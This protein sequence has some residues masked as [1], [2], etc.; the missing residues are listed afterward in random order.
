MVKQSRQEIQ[1]EFE[2]FSA[3]IARLEALRHELDSLDTTS[4]E[5]EAKAIRVRLKDITALPFLE[6]SLHALK[7]KIATRSAPVPLAVSAVPALQRRIRTLEHAIAEK[8]TLSKNDAHALK[9]IP[10]LERALSLVQKKLASHLQNKNVKVDS[11][12]GVL[13]DTTFDEFV[14][15]LKSELTERLRE[16]EVSMDAQ[17]RADLSA[18]ESLFS[19]RYQALVQELHD[20]YRVRL[21]H[22]VH[23]GVRAQL[24]AEL[25]KRLAFERKK[26]ATQLLQQHARRLE[27]ARL[28]QLHTLSQNYAS[29]EKALKEQLA[30]AE[31]QR[32][33]TFTEKQAKLHQSIA[34]LVQREQAC[35]VRSKQ[36]RRRALAQRLLLRKEQRRLLASRAHIQ[37][38]ALRKS[39]VASK[40]LKERSFTKV[41]AL[42]EQLA[43]QKNH[44]AQ[45]MHELRARERLVAQEETN[46]RMHIAHEKEVL[47]HAFD[48]LH[49]REEGLTAR[50]RA[51]YLAQ[52]VALRER[53]AELH[54]RE[55]NLA[56]TLADAQKV[57]QTEHETVAT[58]LAELKER[59]TQAI[60]HER[61]LGQAHEH[62][63]RVRLRA[64]A[65]KHVKEAKQRAREA[66]RS[67][68]TLL[69]QQKKS[70]QEKM[71]AVETRE[72]SLNVH[73]A[74]LKKTVQQEKERLHKAFA[75]LVAQQRASILQVRREAGEKIAQQSQQHAQEYAERLHAERQKMRQELALRISTQR[76]EFER[77]VHQQVVAQ[78]AHIKADLEADYAKRVHAMLAQHQLALDKKKAELERHVLSQ[79]KKL[80]H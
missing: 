67:L 49:Q 16:R 52:R 6:R 66:H 18:R 77:Q 34:L 22:D 15:H 23:Q 24:Q 47:A 60:A 12:V 75:H 71:K 39:L 74:V 61:A 8:R 25:Q 73:D 17:M 59:T 32:V 44:L 58:R 53:T 54:K 40:A 37:R 64:Q 65:R 48:A 72:R 33:R 29:K 1:Q 45:H 38:E 55:K 50:A 13:V 41:K 20:N 63:L 31:Q 5:K 3:R 80:F 2:A 43:L 62:A 14:H 68:T 76:T 10:L 35:A 46:A 30:L 26:L 7:A 27:E 11:G 42:R 19:Q 79:A 21:V 4:F 28:L 9:E 36:L 70:L 78:T 51:R 69:S 57:A 56:H